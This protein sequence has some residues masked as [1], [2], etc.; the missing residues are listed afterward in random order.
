MWKHRLGA[1]ALVLGFSVAPS[2]AGTALP[3]LVPIIDDEFYPTTVG[4]NESVDPQDVVEG[5]AAAVSDRT[6][7][8]F[9]ASTRNVGPV[10]L[11]L[12]DPGCPD[13]EQFPGPTC[14]NPLFECSPLAGHGH[15]HFTKYAIYELFPA[16][17]A[18]AAA[19]G[20]KQSFCVEDWP[21][22]SCPNAQYTCF[23]QGLTA[24][25]KD[26]YPPYVIGCQYVDATELPGARYV[27]RFTVNYEQLLPESNYDNNAAERVVEVCE[28]T[29]GPRVRLRPAK[30]DPTQVRWKVKG[31][32]GVR[33]PLT[34]VDPVADGAMV[35]I[36]TDTATLVDV[37]V[38]GK[39]TAPCDAKDGWKGKG[40][41][42][43]YANRSG[44][45]DA[46]CS[47]ATGG[48]RSLKVST[49]PPKSGDGAT[50]RYVASG[51]STVAAPIARL[52][53]TVG[54][55]ATLGPCWAGSVTCVEGACI[56]ESADDVFDD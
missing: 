34:T 10:D 51:T 33:A 7:V 8:H 38:P 44:F 40:K 6:L 48:L 15:P 55:G 30:K 56:P 42:A 52:R 28:G 13:C 29:P 35:R 25:C 43:H 49:M 12:G 27:L 17:G 41:R 14:V 50:L 31:T 2:T 45:V 19:T 11:V 47:V 36:E 26:V 5:C 4:R 54:L 21:D 1:T 9:A 20:H 18:P 46:G 23:D 22:S 24:G 16:P 53:A 3:D 39:G 37:A 32:A